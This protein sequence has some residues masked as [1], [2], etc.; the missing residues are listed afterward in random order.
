MWSTIEE[1]ESAMCR[2]RSA[3]HAPSALE[4]GAF[5]EQAALAAW[6]S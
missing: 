1:E 2:A 5:D 6:C 3:F 4:I